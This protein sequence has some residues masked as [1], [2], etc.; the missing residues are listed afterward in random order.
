MP[1]TAC[2]P[3]PFLTATECPPPPAQL[4]TLTWSPRFPPR[5]CLSVS[6]EPCYI[7]ILLGLIQDTENTSLTQTHMRV[8]LLLMIM[9]VS[10]ATL[11]GYQMNEQ[12]GD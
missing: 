4:V 7:S 11:R 5:S 12:N 1:L 2:N 10:V 6:Q 8:L 9:F 3:T